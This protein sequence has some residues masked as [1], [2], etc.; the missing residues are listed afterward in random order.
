MSFKDTEEIRKESEQIV[1]KGTKAALATNINSQFFAV[2]LKLMRDE[3]RSLDDIENAIH[4]VALSDPAAVIAALQPLPPV[5]EEAELKKLTFN[6]SQK[7]ITLFDMGERR[8]VRR[9]QV[10]GQHYLYL[11]TKVLNEST[12]NERTLEELITL[13]DDL[14]PMKLATVYQQ[15]AQG[16]KITVTE[17]KLENPVEYGLSAEQAAQIIQDTIAE[18]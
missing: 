4:A 7:L 15:T 18:V 9:A 1:S 13:R 2:V 11:V 14:Q 10:N 5:N 6:F 3:H 17:T 16:T 8:R 12:T